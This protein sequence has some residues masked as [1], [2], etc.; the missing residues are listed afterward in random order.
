M[1]SAARECLALVRVVAEVAGALGGVGLDRGAGSA[2]SAIRG[3]SSVHARCGRAPRLSRPPRAARSPSRRSSSPRR[4]RAAEE[5]RLVDPADAATSPS[6]ARALACRPSPSASSARSG[7][8]VGK[9]SCRCGCLSSRRH[10]RLARS[11]QSPSAPSQIDHVEREPVAGA[12]LAPPCR[13]APA[14]PRP[15]PAASGRRC[16]ARRR[17]FDHALLR[18][19]PAG[20]I[21]DRLAQ[22]RDPVLDLAQSG[23]GECPIA[24][25]ASAQRAPSA[26]AWR[27]APNAASSGRAAPR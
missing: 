4:G 2:T 7:L 10:H 17:R 23:S 12:A 8:G 24:L 19:K 15:G 14:R 11:A 21:W 18:S 22:P 20:E 25:S 13:P 5:L 1:P 6:D 27:A 16:A 3:R 26:P 9:G